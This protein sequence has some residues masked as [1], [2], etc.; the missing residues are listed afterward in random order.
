MLK[1]K[2]EPAMCMKTNAAM[3]ICPVKYTAF[4]RIYA[5]YIIIDNHRAGIYSE[6]AQI[7]R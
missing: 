4:T 3:T 6:I 1:M 5:H 7:P 2:I